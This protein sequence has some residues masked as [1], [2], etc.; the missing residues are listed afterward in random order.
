MSDPTGDKL[1]AIKWQY[2]DRNP[3]VLDE[4]RQRI[5]N[6]G[7]HFGLISYSDLVDGVAFSYPNI[8]HGEPFWITPGNWSG[9]HRKIIGEAL[10]YISM[11]TY[12][13]AGLMA[14]ALVIGR[15]ESKPSD[16]FFDWVVE[17]GLLPSMREDDVLRYWSDQVNKAHHWYKYGK[18]ANSA[19]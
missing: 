13:E 14:S 3:A 4:L 16:I 18:K 12:F 11:E 7:K 9:L 17:L 10:G 6:V 8:N 2:A 15:V 1:R 19:Y 5:A